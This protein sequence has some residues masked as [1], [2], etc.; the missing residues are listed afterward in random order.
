MAKIKVV[1]FD[2]SISNFAIAKLEIDTT[3]LGVTVN[4]LILARTEPD[5][6]KTTLKTSDDLRRAK[7][8][9]QAMVKGC[10]G[11]A[12]A[13]S[14]IP[15]SHATMYQAAILNT[16]MVVGILSSCPLPIIQVTPQQVKL[17]AVGH[18]RMGHLEAP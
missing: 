16:G 14:E 6:R 9:Q 8:V 7:E 1:A 17:A 18:R 10:E 3:T 15:W 4:D 5:S 13:F 2:P 11:A 12:F